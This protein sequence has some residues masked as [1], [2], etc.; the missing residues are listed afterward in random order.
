MRTI[1]EIN[2]LLKYNIEKEKAKYVPD[3]HKSIKNL[4]FNPEVFKFYEKNIKYKKIMQSDLY[5]KVKQDDK[6]FTKLKNQENRKINYKIKQKLNTEAEITNVQNKIKEIIQ[7]LSKLQDETFEKE[8][9]IEKKIEAE[10][11]TFKKYKDENDLLKLE[12]NATKKSFDDII[13]ETNL[14]KNKYEEKLNIAQISVNSKMKEINQRREILSHLY[15]PDLL[16]PIKVETSNIQMDLIKE[17]LKKLPIPLMKKTTFNYS[18]LNNLNNAI[19]EQNN[20]G[21]STSINEN[22]LTTT[23]SGNIEF[24]KKDN[25][26][27]AILKSSIKAR[28]KK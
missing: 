18:S 17:R 27:K 15:D 20:T 4:K 2:K 3:L 16:T 9:E 22:I 21:I 10:K 23:T 13:K 28:D 11:K 12:Y 26:K 19:S 14:K 6:Y 24:K 8:K 1:E 25:I 7:N 5:K